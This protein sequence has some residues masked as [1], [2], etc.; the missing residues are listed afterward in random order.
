MMNVLLVVMNALLIMMIVQL[1]IMNVLLIMMDFQLIIK[2]ES[3]GGGATGATSF[4]EHWGGGGFSQIVDANVIK[5]GK[6][7]K[8][9]GHRGRGSENRRFFVDVIYVG[10]LI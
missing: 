6:T 1:V 8:I 9:C 10:S 2:S 5:I 4:V 3:P 7:W